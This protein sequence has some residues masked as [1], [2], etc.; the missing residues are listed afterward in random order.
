MPIII[1]PNKDLRVIQAKKD[2]ETEMVIKML[3]ENLGV[4]FISK[5]SELSIQEIE[6]I[7]QEM[8]GSNGKN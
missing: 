6:R 5:I 8:N 1:D 4:P 3:Q 7:R 2:K